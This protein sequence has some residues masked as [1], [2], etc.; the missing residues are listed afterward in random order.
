MR[1]RDWIHLGVLVGLYTLCY[2]YQP[3]ITFRVTCVGLAIIGTYHLF[4]AESHAA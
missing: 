1:T 2:L 4:K 3:E